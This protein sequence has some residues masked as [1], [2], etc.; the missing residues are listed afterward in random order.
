[1][2]GCVFEM[3]EIVVSWYGGIIEVVFSDVIIVVFGFLFVY[4]DDV[5]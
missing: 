1:V 3:F 4:E 2:I 5:L